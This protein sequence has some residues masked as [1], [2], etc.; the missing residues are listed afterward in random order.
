MYIYYFGLFIYIGGTECTTNNKNMAKMN[1]FL[2]NEQMFHKG[3]SYCNA[4][5]LQ[6][7]LVQNEQCE[8]QTKDY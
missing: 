7:I 2:Y 5:E 8:G 6:Y 3:G 4:V 1:H